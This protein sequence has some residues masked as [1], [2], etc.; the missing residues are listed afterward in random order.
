MNQKY[1]LTESE[2][3]NDVI[4]LSALEM[5]IYTKGVIKHDPNKKV[6]FAAAEESTRMKPLDKLMD[7][8]MYGWYIAESKTVQQQVKDINE[9]KDYILANVG[10]MVCRK[11]A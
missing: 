4:S 9:F 10:R 2:A 8:Y 5:S 6:P 3:L 7:K 1:V 11:S